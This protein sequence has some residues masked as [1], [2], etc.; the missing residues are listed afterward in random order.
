MRIGDICK[1][2]KTAIDWQDRCLHFAPKKTRYSSRAIVHIPISDKTLEAIKDIINNEPSSPFV[3]P[4]MARTYTDQQ[5]LLRRDWAV[6]RKASG[7]YGKGY[8]QGYGFHSFR[9]TFF[10]RLTANG[11]SPVLI[12]DMAG[13][14]LNRVMTYAHPTLEDKRKALGLCP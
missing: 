10:T 2:E 9:H 3:M 6:I 7:Y 14:S 1:L 13:V 8:S 4:L 11:V 5:S 12:A